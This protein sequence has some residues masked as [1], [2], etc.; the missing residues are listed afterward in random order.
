MTAEPQKHRG[1]GRRCLPGPQF[2]GACLPLAAAAMSGGRAAGQQIVLARGAGNALGCY[3]LAVG[4][5][6]STSRPL[7][8]AARRGDRPTLEFYCTSV[9]ILPINGSNPPNPARP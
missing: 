5:G 6:L 9:D 1:P 8:G 7:S 3:R 4:P 2:W